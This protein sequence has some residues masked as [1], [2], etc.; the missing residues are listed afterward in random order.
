MGGGHFGGGSSS[1]STSSPSTSRPASHSTS[2]TRSQ[3][4]SGFILDVGIR[5]RGGPRAD[6]PRARRIWIN[7]RD[8]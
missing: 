1:H 2:T 6:F 5:E 4:L 7:R 3:G 8:R